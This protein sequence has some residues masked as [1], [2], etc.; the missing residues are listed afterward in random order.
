MISA[1]LAA[2][3][4][5]ATPL[6]QAPADLALVPTDSLVVAHLDSVV[7]LRAAMQSNQF[8]KFTM[9]EQGVMDAFGVQLPPELLIL[10]KNDP[11]EAELATLGD[12]WRLAAELIDS[13]EGGITAYVRPQGFER[14]PTV[15]VIVEPGAG[16]AEFT[17]KMRELLA[18]EEQVQFVERQGMLVGVPLDSLGEGGME[19]GMVFGDG[20]FAMVMGD[21]G[22]LNGTEFDRLLG[23]MAGVEGQSIFDNPRFG[24]AQRQLS[25]QGQ[26]DFFLDLAPLMELALKEGAAETLPNGMTGAEVMEQ[27]GISSM[28]YVV[29]RFGIGAGENTDFELLAHVPSGTMVS[30]LLDNFGSLPMGLMRRLPADALSVTGMNFDISGFVNDAIE[31]SDTFMEGASAQAEMG[32][33]MVTQMIGLDLREDLLGQLTGDIVAFQRALPEGGSSA[34][35]TSLRGM[36]EISGTTAGYLVGV[37]DTSILEGTIEDLIDFGAMQ[38]DMDLGIDSAQ[39]GAVTVYTPI[40]DTGGMGDVP[41]AWGFAP[42]VWGLGMRNEVVAELLSPQPEGF[43]SAIDDKVFG[44]VIRANSGASSFTVGRTADQLVAMISGMQQLG[45]LAGGNQGMEQLIDG[46]AS[47]EEDQIRA[48]FQG[49]SVQTLERTGAGLRIHGYSQ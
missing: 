47:I 7:G 1:L 3:A 32:L 45:D 22:S 48:M 2:Q 8:F 25:V 23:R 44:P 26:M 5:L 30:R 43:K 34:D 10:M 21:N 31:M 46:L 33:A 20:I 40:V 11:S 36:L 13:I 24:A 9:G 17:A 29:G 18:E 41:F 14:S 39:F 38:G 27:A 6:I 19:A 35:P 28:E 4:V 49:V 15:G 16:M 12:E 37:R 42:G